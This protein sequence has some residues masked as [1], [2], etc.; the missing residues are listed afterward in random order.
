ME[1]HH[2]IYGCEKDPNN[3]GKRIAKYLFGSFDSRKEA[4]SHR[5]WLLTQVPED[6]MLAIITKVFIKEEG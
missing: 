6:L 3:P 2:E 5:D 1:I 4:E